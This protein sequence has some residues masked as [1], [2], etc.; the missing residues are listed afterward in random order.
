MLAASRPKNIM[1]YLIIIFRLESEKEAFDAEWKKGVIFDF[2]FSFL[3]SSSILFSA[4]HLAVQVVLCRVCGIVKLMLCRK[5]V[6]VKKR[7]EGYV[8]ING[9]LGSKRIV[10]KRSQEK[11]MFL[12]T[13][14]A[15]ILVKVINGDFLPFFPFSLLPFLPSFLCNMNKLL[16]LQMFLWV[17]GELEMSTAWRTLYIHNCMA[18]ATKRESCFLFKI[19]FLCHKI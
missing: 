7:E 16:I 2:L 18:L 9:Y 6:S 15:S 19:I 4:S 3:S 5:C 17:S 11:I 10:C 12:Q 1:R 13:F 8:C 14:T